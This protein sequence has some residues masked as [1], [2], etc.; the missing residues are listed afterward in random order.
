MLA[1]YCEND[2]PFQ[3]IGAGGELEGYAVELVREIQRRV[4]SRVPIEMVPWAR[5][6]NEILKS[7]GVVLFSMSRSAEREGLFRWVGPIAETAFGFYCRADSLVRVDSL[8]GAKKLRAIGVVQDDI[9]HQFLAANGFANLEPV[10]DNS[11]NLK[12]LFAGRID[13]FA[14]SLN[15]I[16]AELASAGRKKEDVRLLY[17][18]YRVD[19]YIAMSKTIPPAAAAAWNGALESMREDGFFREVMDRWYPGRALPVGDSSLDGD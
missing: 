5:G 18:F 16:E 11:T 9:R 7:P 2:P 3:F 1:V 13:V 6:Y 10:T 15:D 17:V 12:K 14:G 19:V 8:D 4:G